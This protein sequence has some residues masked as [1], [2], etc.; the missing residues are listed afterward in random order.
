M[1]KETSHFLSYANQRFRKTRTLFVRMYGWEWIEYM[2]TWN[3]GNK[4]YVVVVDVE[5]TTR[6][7]IRIWYFITTMVTNCSTL[8]YIAPGTATETEK[9]ILRIRYDIRLYTAAFYVPYELPHIWCRNRTFCLC[10]YSTMHL[11]VLAYHTTRIIRKK[12]YVKCQFLKINHQ[13][14]CV[15]FLSMTFY[16][17]QLPVS[18]L[19]D[20]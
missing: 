7:C 5:G 20:L 9:K 14:I 6:D 1:R 19:L 2:P 18:Y 11:P 8:S 3:Y 16:V 15:A 13:R 12:K 10:L 17:C 4:L